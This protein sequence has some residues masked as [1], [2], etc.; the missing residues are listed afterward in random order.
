[1]KFSLVILS[2]VAVAGCARHSLLLVNNQGKVVRCETS[3]REKQTASTTQEIVRE[4]A[5]HNACVREYERL[6]FV[7]MPTGTTGLHLNWKTKPPTIDDV[8]GPALKAGIQKGDILTQLDDQEV[9][10]PMAVLSLVSDKDIGDVV[11]VQIRRGME[12][13]VFK[14]RLGKRGGANMPQAPLKPLNAVATTLAPSS[15]NP[16]SPSSVLAKSTRKSEPVSFINRNGNTLTCPPETENPAAP[17]GCAV[18][19]EKLGFVR[20]PNVSAG[21]SLDWN[22]KTMKIVQVTGPASDAGV[23]VDDILI[24]CDANK[25][26]EPIAIF[27][28][29]GA[30]HPG[31][32]IAVK[33][34]RSGKPMDFTYQLINKIPA[35][36]PT[37]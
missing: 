29:I 12:P 25:I 31:D 18:N 3:G 5:I 37:K 11:K 2:I 33:V 35:M 10:E 22:S 1:M 34:I 21:I 26:A 13:L 8:A 14:L 32:Y 23:K 28:I 19:A 15:S 24:E 7:R 30:K 4:E 36:S 17:S 9:T 27:K 20:V 16:P 6:G